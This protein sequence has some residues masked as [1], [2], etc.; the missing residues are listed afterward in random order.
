MGTAGLGQPEDEA[1]DWAALYRVYAPSVRRLVAPLVPAA[2]VED[3]VQETFIRL[4]RGWNRFD[5]SMPLWPL[6]AIMARRVC[7]DRWRSRPR[8]S[9][10]VSPDPA[11]GEAALVDPLADVEARRALVE[12]MHLLAP[13]DRRVI[14]R[15]LLDGATRAEVA[16][17]EG[18]TTPALRVA[19]MRARRRFRVAYAT[20]AERGLL[21]GW[22][23]VAEAR[24]WLRRRLFMGDGVTADLARLCLCI[25]AVATAAALTLSTLERP[26]PARAEVFVAVQD[27]V[28][29]GVALPG[30]PADAGLSTGNP[31]APVP[32]GSNVESPRRVMTDE[33]GPAVALRRVE[34]GVSI[35]PEKTT[36]A[37]YIEWSDPFGN[38]HG[39]TAAE[40]DCSNEERRVL[41]GASCPVFRTLPLTESSLT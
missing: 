5:Q 27:N 40:V 20:A 31:V 34:H 1:V 16:D 25:T 12:A 41:A 11:G 6:L 19:L 32:P 39:Y 7:A 4:H 29:E 13:R 8:E 9:A 14:V 18:L 10:Y 36:V 28:S 38:G 35:G 23:F 2:D 30:V 17:E 33:R 3:A 21:V 15:C 26:V 24:S 37:I 22:P